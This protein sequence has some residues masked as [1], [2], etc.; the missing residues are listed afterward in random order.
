M[1]RPRWFQNLFSMPVAA[2][3]PSDELPRIAD[4]IA[5]AEHTHTGQICFA[6]ERALGMGNVLNG[7]TARD[8]AAQL[9]AQLGV[10]NTARNNGV[11]LYILTSEHR[12]ELIADRGYDEVVSPEQWRG[13]CALL[14]DRLKQD[15]GV[16]AVVE[17]I[18]QISALVA[19]EYPR[20]PNVVLDHPNELPNTP[21]VL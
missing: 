20:D 21:F 6:I 1:S 14:E 5:Q 3:I 13:I 7:M 16:D 19:H 18:G 10:W 17:A 12:I 4:A 15:N 8:R 2:L 9:F 11:L